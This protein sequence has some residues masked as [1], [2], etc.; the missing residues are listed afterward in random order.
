MLKGLCILA[1]LAVVQAKT[2]PPLTWGKNG[3]ITTAAVAQY[4]INSDAANSI[5]GLLPSNDNGQ[6]QTVVNWADDVRHTKAYEWS[7]PLH[8][9]N[10]P[11]W[12]CDYSRTRDCVDGG[13]KMFC[14]DGAIQNYSARVS[15]QNL[16]E[17]QQTEALKFLIHFIGDIH[18]PL[19]CGFTSDLGGNTITGTFEDSDWN[20]HAIWDTAIIDK[21]VSDDFNQNLTAYIA[22]LADQIQ[23]NWSSQANEWATCQSSAKFNA[24]SNEWATESVTLACDYSYVDVDGKT[25][26]ESGFNLGDAYYGRNMPI[27]EMQLAKAAVRMATVLNSIWP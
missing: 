11:D 24:C 2:R 1:V 3:H 23:G 25:H 15:N 5:M 6:L 14:A 4:L 16:P 13:K 9:I 22:Y 8:F 20:L 26:I 7:A 19:H 27:V 12:A 17:A 18:Q 21:R 10:T